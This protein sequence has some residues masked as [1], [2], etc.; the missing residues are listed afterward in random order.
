MS[1]VLVSREGSVIE[2]CLNR[3]RKKNALTGAMYDAI[4]ATLDKAGA[5]PEVRVVL[6]SAAGDTF[7]A[8]NDIGEFLAMAAD[9]ANAPPARFIRAITL[10]K[11]PIV[12][13]VNGPAVGVGATM[14]LHCDLVYASPRATFSAPFVNLALVPEGGASRLMPERFGYQRAAALLLLAETIDAETAVAIG[15]INAVVDDNCL[16]DFARAKA[17]DLAG[18]P[19][20]AV[21]RARALMR[22][23]QDGLEA[24]MH[25]EMRAFA[26]ALQSD[27]AREALTSFLTGRAVRPIAAS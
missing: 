7:T 10:S 22:A 17:A 20:Q 23:S 19:P 13:A 12:A 11:K 4:A 14:L 5:D 21:E 8:G 9:F 2:I 3:P 27:E 26:T 16:L 18:K 24:H 1:D 15:M 25:E 6:L